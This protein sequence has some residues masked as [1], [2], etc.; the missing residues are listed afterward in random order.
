MARQEATTVVRV[1]MAVVEEGLSDVEGW[2]GFLLGLRRVD[3]RGS[4]RWTFLVHD[5]A[6]P[7]QVDVTVEIDLDLDAGGSRIC[8]RAL[9]GPRFD[10]TWTL[11]PDGDRTRVELV[12][13]AD[14]IGFAAG[15]AELLGR[16]DD[17]AVL[18]LRRLEEHLAA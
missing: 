17:T 7:R 2:P 3:R 15:L 4:G 9:C 10:G 12:L 13:D 1:P 16:S 11:T 6:R 14:P 5:G 18:D 8:W